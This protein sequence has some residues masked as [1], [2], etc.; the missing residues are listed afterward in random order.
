VGFRIKH[1]ASVGFGKGT[2]QLVDFPKKQFA[3]SGF[4]EVVLHGWWILIRRGRFLDSNK[5]YAG[6]FL[7]HSAKGQQISVLNIIVI[8]DVYSPYRFADHKRV[9][10]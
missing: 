4:F 2:L 9:I 6:Y 3:V 8:M 10:L 5:G 1:F 7:T